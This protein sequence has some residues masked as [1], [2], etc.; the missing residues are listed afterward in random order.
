VGVVAVFGVM[1][2]VV[3]TTGPTVDP[4]ATV[5]IDRTGLEPVELVD[6]GDLGSGGTRRGVHRDGTI[7]PPAPTPTGGPTVLVGA[8]D[9]ETTDPGATST[10]LVDPVT[11]DPTPAPVEL[12]PSPEELEARAVLATL[13]EL[14]TEPT[15]DTF[16]F[17]TWDD[18]VGV[19]LADDYFDLVNGTDQPEFLPL[20]SQDGVADGATDPAVGGDGMRMP[21]DL[22]TPGLEAPMVTTEDVAMGLTPEPVSGRSALA[23]HLV[24]RDRSILDQFVSMV[25]NGGAGG[26]RLD[27]VARI[28]Q[29]SAFLPADPFMRATIGDSA[30]YLPIT[31]PDYRSYIAGDDNLLP[32]TDEEEGLG[33]G[34]ISVDASDLEGFE[35]ESDAPE[36][37]RRKRLA[38]HWYEERVPRE[39]VNRE[40]RLLTPRVGA[41]RVL[42]AGD[43]VFEG[44]LFAVGEGRIWVDTVIGRMV[45]EGEHTERVDRVDLDPTKLAGGDPGMRNLAGLPRVRV[46]ARGGTFVGRQIQRDGDRVTLVTDQGFRVTLDSTE[47][48]MAPNQDVIVDIKKRRAQ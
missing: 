14:S 15:P 8:T 12:P 25:R 28:G 4:G 27:Y 11:E 44:R 39:Y 30:L 22:S 40:R 38:D 45:L 10:A 21:P 2:K 35:G 42:Y 34:S 48:A 5:E 16:R 47:I 18:V 33:G 3:T 26:T 41:V 9:P 37:S 29:E 46:R 36:S 1:W 7:D 17:V 43:E 19:E 24:S 20:S 23:A 32:P 13:E 31:G 6:S